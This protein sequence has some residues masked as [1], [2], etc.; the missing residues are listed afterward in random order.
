MKHV[1]IDLYGCNP[2][3]LADASLLQYVLDEYPNRV[4]MQK[5]SPVFLQEIKTS[6]PLDDG[7]SGFVIIATSHI[8]LHAWPHY[9]MVNLDIFSC[10]DFQTVT[11]GDFA[12]HLFQT[13]QIEIHEVERALQS[14]RGIMRIP[15]SGEHH[16]P[17]LSRS[18][19]ERYRWLSESTWPVRRE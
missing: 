17:T 15:E 13:A 9:G 5:V 19:S 2:Q 14:P 8:S 12:M 4:G 18:S 1:M 6:S 16:Q 7:M 3:L 10:E 11:V